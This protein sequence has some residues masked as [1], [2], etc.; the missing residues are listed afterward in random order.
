MLHFATLVTDRFLYRSSL[1]SFLFQ[2]DVVDT[3]SRQDWVR[4][5][6]HVNKTIWEDEKLS[7][8]AALKSDV[9][10]LFYHVLNK[11]LLNI[12]SSEYQ[13]YFIPLLAMETLTHPKSWKEVHYITPILLKI[14]W[15][16]LNWILNTFLP[17]NF[18]IWYLFK[19]RNIPVSLNCKKK[20]KL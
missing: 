11:I 19:Y 9:Q 18:S 4:K 7:K 2:V 6:E 17:N 15:H 16:M 8:T 3:T 20:K 5:S 13:W 12:T 1:T 14:E 10:D